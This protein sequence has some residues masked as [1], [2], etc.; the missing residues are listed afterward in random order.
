MRR[1]QRGMTLLDVMVAVVVLSLG[2]V[3]VLAGSLTQLAGN[4]EARLLT[5]A[6]AVAREAMERVLMQAAP[7]SGGDQVDRQGRSGARVAAVGGALFTRTWTIT[8]DGVGFLRVLV[9]VRYN[10]AGGRAH[11]VQLHGMR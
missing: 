1:R 5:E 4:A 11:L 2:A 9:Q 7:Q 6:T 10:D 3:G 8:D